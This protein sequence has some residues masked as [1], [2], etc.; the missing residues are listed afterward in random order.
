MQSTYVKLG[1]WPETKVDE[2]AAVE[3]KVALR[4]KRMG[5]G[6]VGPEV[7]GKEIGYKERLNKRLRQP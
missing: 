1:L 5:M 2:S 3:A 7:V 4:G 6:M